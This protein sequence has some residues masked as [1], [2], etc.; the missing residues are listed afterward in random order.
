M[1]DET[2]SES[3]VH[4]RPP[5]LARCR[6]FSAHVVLGY[7]LRPFSLWHAALLDLLKNPFGFY[8][9]REDDGFDFAKA[10]NFPRHFLSGHFFLDYAALQSA[11]AI[12]RCTYPTWPASGGFAG[13]ISRLFAARRYSRILSPGADLS[14]LTIDS[15]YLAELRKL[16]SYFF[17][18]RTR[19]I[20][21]SA[22]N[23]R[24]VQTPWYLV[25]VAGLMRLGLSEAKAWN[26]PL[27]EGCWLAAA[28][29]EASGNRIDILTEQ[30]RLDFAAAGNPDFQ[31]P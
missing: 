2:F 19:P 10:F 8:D 16:G 29:A 4:Q 22:D 1:L 6:G 25:S 21:A 13:T 26:T 20:H 27:G 31:S 28:A 15:P 17:E 5:L 12:C 30:D 9:A 11:V 3:V 24:P 18:Y 7:R 14:S 23:S